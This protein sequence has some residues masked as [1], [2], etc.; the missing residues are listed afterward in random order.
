MEPNVR[1]DGPPQ[2]LE[3]ELAAGEQELKS[4]GR[5]HSADTPAALAVR[6]HA[7]CF[8]LF[9]VLQQT[10]R[11]IDLDAELVGLRGLRLKSRSVIDSGC[12]RRLAGES[13]DQHHPPYRH[14]TS[15]SSMALQIPKSSDP[16]AGVAGV[17]VRDAFAASKT[18]TLMAADYSQIEVR[19]R[20]STNPTEM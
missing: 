6:K 7:V 14:C 8:S 1:Q 4:F 20:P 12:P 5:A 10:R 19:L 3:A 17:N 13:V 2:L 18:F 11:E 16:L 9:N 15:P